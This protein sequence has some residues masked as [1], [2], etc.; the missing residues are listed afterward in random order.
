MSDDDISRG[1]DAARACALK[2]LSVMEMAS[3]TKDLS[4]VKKVVRLEG[5][6]NSSDTFSNH[7]KIINGASDT[8]CEVLGSEVGAHSRFAVGCSNLPLNVTVEV[9]AIVELVD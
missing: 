1:V 4:G 9:G 3:P 6:V 7:P 8:I 5:F 2:L